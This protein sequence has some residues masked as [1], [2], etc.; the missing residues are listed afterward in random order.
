MEDGAERD[1]VSGVDGVVRGARLGVERCGW[2]CG[3]KMEG[4][5]R[6]CGGVWTGERGVVVGG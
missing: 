3:W 4:S 5:E 6:G 2:G 1:W